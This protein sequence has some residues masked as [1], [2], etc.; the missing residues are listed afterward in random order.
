MKIVNKTTG[1]VIGYRCEDH[2]DKHDAV[3]AINTNAPEGGE[4]AMCVAESIVHAYESTFEKTLLWPI[5]DQAR[6]RLNLLVPGA[7]DSFLEDARAQINAA[8][9]LSEADA[10]LESPNDPD[11]ILRAIIYAS[12]G[13][14]GH[15]DCNHSIEPWKRARAYLEMKGKL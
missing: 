12:D 6:G 1:D 3:P 4:C 5:I 13:C 10:D 7:G 8:K 14:V 9:L 15:R 2:P 11:A